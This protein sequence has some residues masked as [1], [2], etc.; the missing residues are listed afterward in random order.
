[1]SAAVFVEVEVQVQVEV[2][3]LSCSSNNAP[4]VVMIQ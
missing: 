2:V 4:D 3:I 1:M